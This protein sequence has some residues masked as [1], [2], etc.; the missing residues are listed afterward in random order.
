[1]KLKFQPLR[2]ATIFTLV[3]FTVLVGLGTWQVKRLEWKT[4]LLTRIE[5]RMSQP[6][7]PMPEKIKDS[8]SWEYRRV[9]LAGQFLHD[10]E[11][12]VKPRTRDGVNGYHMIAPFRRASGG[13]VMI[14]RGW[15]SDA[16]MPKARRPKGFL[17]IEGIVQL[18]HTTSFT[19]RNAPEKKDWYWADAGAM[20]AAAKL[21][22][23]SPV[24]VAMASKEP[25]VYPAGGKVTVNIR[26]DHWQ[27]AVF[28]YLMAFLSQAFFVLYH[29]KGVSWKTTG[30]WKSILG[31]IRR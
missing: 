18:P 25:G 13:I 31:V 8:A 30:N 16:L 29:L 28:W 21:K 19:P 17:Q 27:Y 10:H 23:V 14:N 7:V 4:N 15:I 22:N 6:P 2:G 1:M 3:V 11:F 20:A 5:S 12:L 26:N 9:T 24:L